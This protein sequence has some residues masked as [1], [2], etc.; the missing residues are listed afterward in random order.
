[1]DE[2]GRIR[3]EALAAV[4]SAGSTAELRELRVRYLGKKSELSR[5]LGQIGRLP[6]DVRRTLGAAA[7]EARAAIEAALA[8]RERVLQEVELAA[9]LEAERIDV[10]LP[11]TPVPRGHL[12][13]LRQVWERIEDIFIGMGY[14]VAEG[15]EVET[16]WYN[17]EALNI[18]KGHPARDAQDSLFIEGEDVLLR[19][20]TSNTQVRYMQQVAP[21]LPVRIIVPGRVFRRDTE[22]ATHLSMFHQ[23][24]GL[25]VDRGISMGDLKGTLLEMARGLFG[26]DSRVRMRPSYF[27]FTEPSAE[28]DVSCP[29]CGGSGCRV[30]KE[31]GW[32]EILGSGMVHPTVLRNGGYDPDEVTGFAFGMGIERVAM[33]LYGV[34]DLRHFI[35]GDMRFVRQF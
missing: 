25:V 6:P 34:D 33:I 21:R 29:F 2:V 28:V 32:I 5:L 24:E 16:D 8:E 13:L 35:A 27:P 3:A 31:T 14:E 19:T 17:F 15:P 12:H 30:C 7:N 18:P 9:R 20:H 23:V 26:P 22:D 11:G 1:M 10:T 4:Q